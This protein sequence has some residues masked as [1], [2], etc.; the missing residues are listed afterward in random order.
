MDE[1]LICKVLIIVLILR[2][3]A[4]ITTTAII[5]DKGTILLQSFSVV[6]PADVFSN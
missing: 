4:T 3:D 5:K 6:F 1:H 2:I